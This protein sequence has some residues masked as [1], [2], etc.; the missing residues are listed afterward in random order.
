MIN[1]YPVIPV[2]ELCANLGGGRGRGEELDVDLLSFAYWA[3][4]FEEEIFREA[5]SFSCFCFCSSSFPENESAS[6]EAK[7]LLD[8]KINDTNKI[9]H[10]I[11]RDSKAIF[12]QRIF[13]F[14]TNH[15][16]VIV[17]I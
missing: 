9:K 13:L 11:T 10:T 6:P 16:K 17:R 3:F 14:K 8:K 5:T 4:W 7:A 12:E 15:S 2:F 1:S